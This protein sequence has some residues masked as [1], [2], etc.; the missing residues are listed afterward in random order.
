MIVKEFFLSPEIFTN[1]YCNGIIAERL[2][3]LLRYVKNSGF[4][5]SLNNKD[6]FN[7]VNKFINLFDDNDKEQYKNKFMLTTLLKTL[8]TQKRIEYHPKSK[9][10]PEKEDDWLNIAKETDSQRKI[11][12]IFSKSGDCS[13]N[14]HT[15][16]ELK[17]ELLERIQEP[18]S[19]Y[20]TKNID[21]FAKVFQNILG[22][23]REVNI[24]DPYFYIHKS[25]FKTLEQVAKYLGY[26]R[27]ANPQNKG[28]I[29]IHCSYCGH[30]SKQRIDEYNM[31]KWPSKLA[32]L[33][34][35]G[36][37]IKIYVWD[38]SKIPDA[39]NRYLTTESVGIVIDAGF[40]IDDKTPT[41]ISLLSNKLRQE[42]CEIFGGE[43]PESYPGLELKYFVTAS[44]IE[45]K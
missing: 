15:M 7:N 16:D 10:I 25:C 13:F 43:H 4:L 2:E 26:F 9:I 3:N 8:D 18:V 11:D 42:K 34:K 12:F 44:R 14:T 27:G 41:N 17:G 20:E 39:H 40:D 21:N 45:K 35:Y 28:T 31:E 33:K 19:Y 29:N 22:Y 23:A 5:I 37:I 6:W 24:I 1:I 32:G 36:H 38:M 30:D